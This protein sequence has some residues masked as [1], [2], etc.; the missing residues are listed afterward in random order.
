MNLGLKFK[1]D[2][3]VIKI[4]DLPIVDKNSTG[5]SLSKMHIL[6]WF[7]VKDLVEETSNEAFEKLEQT[8][9]KQ[10]QI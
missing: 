4:T 2:I 9:I 6:E 7:I 10:Q 1:E 8:E 5:T 3:E